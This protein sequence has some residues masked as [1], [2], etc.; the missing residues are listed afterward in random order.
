MADTY[1]TVTDA[2]L[3][4]ALQQ[5]VGWGWVGAW[6]DDKTDWDFLAHLIEQSYRMTAPKRLLAWIDAPEPLDG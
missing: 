6:L 3:P 5:S 4:P 1:S 2:S